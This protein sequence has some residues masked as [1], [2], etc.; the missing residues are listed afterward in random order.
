LQD[1]S[2]VVIAKDLGLQKKRNQGNLAVAAGYVHIQWG[3]FSMGIHM[4]KLVQRTALACALGAALV[5]P[6]FAH[7][8]LPPGIAKK[9][10][11]RGTSCYS[12][13][14][15]TA[16]C[17][18]F[19]RQ[20][21][22]TQ[23]F[24]G[25]GRTCA[26]CHPANNNFTIDEDYISTLAP[27]DPLFVFET[28]A[29]TL[30]RL[31]TPLLRTKGLICEN[32]DGVG[33]NGDDSAGNRTCVL[34]SVPH[35]LGLRF[36]II[37]DE[38][39]EGIDGGDTPSTNPPA[40]PPFPLAAALG[41]GGDG[42]PNRGS[43]RDF[44]TGAVIQH[45]TKTLARVEGADFRLPTADELDAMEAFQ[46]SLGRK[47][48]FN[49]NPDPTAKNATFNTCSSFITPTDPSLSTCVADGFQTATIPTTGSSDPHYSSPSPTD[50]AQP[51]SM[52]MVFNDSTV[53]L[54]QML[55]FGGVPTTGTRNLRTCAGCHVQG[56]A[57]SPDDVALNTPAPVGNRNRAT[58]A[59]QSPNAPAC[60]AA[61]DGSYP[62]FNADG[63]FGSGKNGFPAYADNLGN[64]T[65]SQDCGAGSSATAASFPYVTCF[66]NFYTYNPTGPNTFPQLCNPNFAAIDQ[67]GNC[68]AKPV[69]TGSTP[70]TDSGVVAPQLLLK[71]NVG[72][73]QDDT[74]QY[75]IKPTK[76]L[77]RRA[78]CPTSTIPVEHNDV[79]YFE[80]TSFFN[81]PS[82]HEAGATPPF[83]HNNIARTLEESVMFYTT[84]AFGNSVSG[85]KRAFR[86]S[87]DNTKAGGTTDDPGCN[88]PGTADCKKAQAIGAFLRA[89]SAI[90][91]E[92]SA[93]RYLNDARGLTGSGKATTV[94]LAINKIKDAI[95]VLS[96]SASN[97]R[98]GGPLG[99][100]FGGT[101][102]IVM[103]SLNDALSRL[104]V[105]ANSP[106]AL[107]TLNKPAMDAAIGSLQA[108][109]MSMASSNYIPPVE[110]T[111]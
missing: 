30:G 19:G 70:P 78:L 75:L 3:I 40:R 45:F 23:T 63:G 86:F 7:Q 11:P 96:P 56:G 5:F 10:P 92:A 54:G 62:V 18:E 51:G 90:D 85:A 49:L 26:S 8:G 99:N 20:L 43:L 41:W 110:S 48:E 98:L 36:S 39:G 67:N 47:T 33:T 79:L 65:G 57:G 109:R 53:T 38:V 15:P 106:D 35:T 94:Q 24:G 59:E 72:I 14:A 77:T 44:A 101:N 37:P 83:F 21:F 28:N 58:G 13:G 46:L 95:G 2:A 68:I 32:L 22:E 87:D 66:K 81:T 61:P 73:D 89:I 27:T 1:G 31:E 4:E 60:I 29:A 34:R 84:P 71:A 104:S 16:G 50:P 55:F 82:L 76:L 6:A 102:G 42:A 69:V 108:A 93:E 64:T 80:G 97:P 9:I 52:A 25:N 107:K 105:N 74:P 17:I 88:S 12:N 100:L 103:K 91:S 111:P